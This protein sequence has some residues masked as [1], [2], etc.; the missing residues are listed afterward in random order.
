M[1]RRG[2]QRGK[3]RECRSM[4][5]PI[6]FP[7]WPSGESG[8]AVCGALC[9]P[10]RQAA[11]CPQTAAHAYAPLALPLAARSNAAIREVP[12]GSLDTFSPERKYH[13]PY[14]LHLRRKTDSAFE[15]KASYSTRRRGGER[16]MANGERPDRR[17]WREEGGERV[18]AV[19]ER[20]RCVSTKDIRRVPQQD[21]PYGGGGSLGSAVVERDSGRSVCIV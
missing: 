13:A 19:G 16:R 5:K 8:Q 3:R 6:R 20:R 7:L 9:A 18:A 15:P 1:Y 14:A 12:G 21:H 2:F 4:K 10:R 11:R 17:Q